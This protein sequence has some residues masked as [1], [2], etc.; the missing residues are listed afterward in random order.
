M[1]ELINIENINNRNKYVICFGNFDGVHLAHQNCFKQLSLYSKKNNAKSLVITFNPHTLE[2]LKPNFTNYII[3][4]NCIKNNYILKS[5]VDFLVSLDIN[6]SILN[7]SAVDYIDYLL[8]KINVLTI[9]IGY[10][11]YFGK[12]REGN[13]NF[14]IKYLKNSDVSIEQFSLY[15]QGNEIIKS[16]LIRKMIINGKVEK[17]SKLLGRNFMLTGEIIRGKGYG[18]KIGFP[19]ANLKLESNRLLIPKNGVYYTKISFDKYKF[20]S[21]SNIGFRPTFNTS[22]LNKSIETYITEDFN[23]DLYNTK[24]KLEFY[25]FIRNEIKFRSKEELVAQIRKDIDKIKN[26]SFHG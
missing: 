25:A 10:D 13:Y 21:L 20:N 6:K 26:R 9:Y 2:L 22:K 19:T 17:V 3:S 7:M 24:I 23:Q 14:L 18:R 11:N 8:K 1:S 4:N 16:S 15:K 5:D 12:N